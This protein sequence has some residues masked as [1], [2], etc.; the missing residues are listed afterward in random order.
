MLAECKNQKP[1][2][3][4]R[5]EAR[6][7]GFDSLRVISLSLQFDHAKQAGGTHPI[8]IVGDCGLISR[9]FKDCVIVRL[10][11]HMVT[12]THSWSLFRNP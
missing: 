6:G 2:F 1:E 5:R 3:Q 12:Q 11:N 7:V 9:K 10:L 8:T 4:E